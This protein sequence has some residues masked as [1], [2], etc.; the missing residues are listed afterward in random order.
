MMT[1]TVQLPDDI[2]QR[3]KRFSQLTGQTLDAVIA[4]ALALSIP[5]VS[6]AMPP[7][8]ELDDDAVVLCAISRCH[9]RKMH[10]IALY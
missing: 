9:R 8:S 3:A 1:Q 10:P 5:A 7:I 6:D 2:Y 4:D